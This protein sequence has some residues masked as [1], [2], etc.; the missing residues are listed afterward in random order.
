MVVICSQMPQS[1]KEN[2]LAAFRYLLKPLVRL[3]VKNAVSFPEF[4]HA[5]KQ[6][7]VDVAANQIKVSGKDPNEEGIS[8]ITSVQTSEIREI[9]HSDVGAKF[10]SS[11]QQPNPLPTVLGGWHTDIRYTGPYG[12]LRDLEFSSSGG[13]TID[14]G[15]TF[16]D[17][18][19]T[20][21]PGV[22]PRALLDELMRTGCVQEVGN[23]FF[24]AV[25][26]SYIPDPLSSG[27]ILLFSRVVHNICETLEVNL[28][29]ESVGGNGLIERTV[30]T[31]HG[32]RRKDLKEFDKFIRGRG[33][34]FADDIDNWLTDRDEEGRTDGIQM[35]VGFYHYIVNED[36][37]RAL[38]KELP[39]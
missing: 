20:Y 39:N 12:V 28:R 26:R 13:G 2:L 23:G 16:S 14:G 15:A 22:S 7:Y 31:V 1:V 32:I 9:L 10:G 36:D 38:S 27:S 8:L 21:C 25:K 11:A 24:R 30:Y 6:A 5:L 35:G 19:T 4:S 33:Q 37:E 3:A 17:L 18:A 29:A 34:I